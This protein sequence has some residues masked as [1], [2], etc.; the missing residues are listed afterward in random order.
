MGIWL[1]ILFALSAVVI[2]CFRALSRKS[3]LKGREPKPLV[4][5][6]AEVQDQV[7]VDVFNEVWLKVGEIFAIDPGLIKPTDTLKAFGS[8]DSWD[9]GKGE[10]AL[11]QWIE[12]ERLGTPPTLTTMLDLAKWVQVRKLGRA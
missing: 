3:F 8:V 5:I 1:L 7:S 4:D 9:L 2:L 11:G 10:D 6:H 12:Q